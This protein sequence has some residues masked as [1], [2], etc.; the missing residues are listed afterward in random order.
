LSGI[1]QDSEDPQAAQLLA[2][3]NELA[4][5]LKPA[6]A[7]TEE[8]YSNQPPIYQAYIIDR[9]KLPLPTD[10]ST[11]ERRAQ[12]SAELRKRMV[13][14]YLCICTQVNQQVR[15]AF[16]EMVL[17]MSD[18]CIRDYLDQMHEVFVKAGLDVAAFTATQV[19]PEL[20]DR[21][22]KTAS[23]KKKEHIPSSGVGSPAETL[24][25]V[26]ALGQLTARLQTTLREDKAL[27]SSERG[28]FVL[29]TNTGEAV[30]GVAL[31]LLKE[32]AEAGFLR[33]VEDGVD[34]WRFR[35]HCSLAAAY[36]FSYRGAYY[37]TRI[38]LSELVALYREEDS[39]RRAEIID[40]IGTALSGDLA[41]LPLFDVPTP[42][43]GDS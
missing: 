25:I 28:L 17:Q 39:K 13:A 15:Y 35:V 43:E 4:P 27:R 6:E 38:R 1:L 31:R 41:P 12:A 37:S 29:K 21:A 2:L 14:A 24:R 40:E 18:K 36:G 33:I 23:A 5:T 10:A 42:A 19:A 30:L 3:A 9:L 20:Q 8:P 26:D 11:K 16:A 22:L 7:S 34:Q 32:A